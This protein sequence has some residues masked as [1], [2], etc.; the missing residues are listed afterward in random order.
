MGWKL[1]FYG[2]VTPA[3]WMLRLLNLSPQSV[4]TARRGR[5]TWRPA[6]AREDFTSQW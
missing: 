1:L 3:A 4:S 6:R 5:T 2:L